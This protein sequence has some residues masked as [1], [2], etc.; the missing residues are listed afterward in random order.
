MPPYTYF[1]ILYTYMI[2]L[3]GGKTSSFSEST[4][5]TVLQKLIYLLS[6]CHVPETSQYFICD[7]LTYPHNCSI[8]KLYSYLF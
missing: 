6:T 4:K 3:S 1:C 8:R 7:Y 2:Y 5:L